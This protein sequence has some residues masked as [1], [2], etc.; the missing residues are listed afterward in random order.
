M[1]L[2]H[3]ADV[4][5]RC[6]LGNVNLCALVLLCTDENYQTHTYHTKVEAAIFFKKKGKLVRI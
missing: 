2:G 4:E 1:H 5:E 3:L 6:T